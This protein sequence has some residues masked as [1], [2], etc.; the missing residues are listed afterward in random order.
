[1][2]QRWRC[3]LHQDPYGLPEQRDHTGERK[4][5]IGEIDFHEGATCTVQTARSG[6]TNG[7]HK[8]VIGLV[9][10]QLHGGQTRTLLLKLLQSTLDDAQHTQERGQRNLLMSSNRQD[11]T[12]FINPAKEVLWRATGLFLSSR[13]FLPHQSY[14][15]AV[16]ASYKVISPSSK[17]SGLTTAASVNH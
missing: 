1:M 15:S 17:P 10:T 4:K 8:D 9:M 16:P 12:R 13:A 3:P 14:A 11:Y 7:T 2:V 5:R 6:K